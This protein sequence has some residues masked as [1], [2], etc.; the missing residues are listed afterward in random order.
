MP[1][2]LCLGWSQIICEGEK[3]EQIPVPLCRGL[4]LWTFFLSQW[5]YTG[6]TTPS[7][8]LCCRNPGGLLHHLCSQHSTLCFVWNLDEQTIWANHLSSVIHNSFFCV[9]LLHLKLLGQAYLKTFSLFDNLTPSWKQSWHPAPG[10]AVAHVV[11]SFLRNK[12]H[13]CVGKRAGDSCLSTVG[14][15]KAFKW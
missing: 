8:I 10:Q 3:K 15:H 6:R 9:P 1:E 12:C 7:L 5:I 14:Q 2:C 4:N 13:Q 11:S